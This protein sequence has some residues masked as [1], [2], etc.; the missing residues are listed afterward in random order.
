MR[1]NVFVAVLG[2]A[3]TEICFARS[4][5]PGGRGFH[6]VVT[7]RAVDCGIF[8][9]IPELETYSERLGDTVSAGAFCFTNAKCEGRPIAKL[10]STGDCLDQGALSSIDNDARCYFKP[11]NAFIPTYV[12]NARLEHP[13]KEC[14]RA[15][16]RK[17]FGRSLPAGTYR[18]GNIYPYPGWYPYPY[19]QLPFSR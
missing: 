3:L 13:N 11:N 6:V 15:N 10:S 5:P 14:S 18:G 1:I 2:I 7:Q 8:T 17:G 16:S 12:S 4:A 9:S 19:P